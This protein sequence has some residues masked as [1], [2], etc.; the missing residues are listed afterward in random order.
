MILLGA[1]VYNEVAVPSVPLAPPVRRTDSLR[2]HRPP[3]ARGECPRGVARVRG[4]STSVTIRW[5]NHEQSNSEIATGL[6]LFVLSLLGL[7]WFNLPCHRPR[8][9]DHGSEFHARR[10]FATA[11]TDSASIVG[12]WRGEP[13]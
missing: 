2:F 9:C 11:S 6:L 12:P 3:G 7:S 1:S 10:I 13:E 8:G 5:T 4:R